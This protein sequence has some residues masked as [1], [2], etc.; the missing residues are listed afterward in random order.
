MF[1]VMA[2]LALM[3]CKTITEIL[4]EEKHGGSEKG[5]QDRSKVGPVKMKSIDRFKLFLDNSKW[6]HDRRYKQSKWKRVL[7]NTKQCFKYLCLCNR[8]KEGDGLAPYRQGE[9]K[10]VIN[11][12][13]TLRYGQ[14][15]KQEV[16]LPP[17][18][19]PLLNAEPSSTV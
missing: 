19:L 12:I 4:K 15:T 8:Q 7:L 18:L 11:L 5:E 17:Y 3:W 16:P 14:E 10:P 2:S 13:Q 6:I 1:M 9:Y